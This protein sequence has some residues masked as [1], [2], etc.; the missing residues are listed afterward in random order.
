MV[1]WTWVYKH[2]FDTLHSVLLDAYPEVGLLNDMV[3]LF[4]VL[5][6]ICFPWLLYQF[7]FPPTVEASNFSRSLITLYLLFVCIIA[8]LIGLRWYVIVFSLH[9][10]DDYLF[11]ALF[12]YLFTVCMFSVGNVYSLLLHIL[13]F[14]YLLF[15]LISLFIL[16]C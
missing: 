9:F 1:Q 14:D 16:V 13:K 11:L 15:L 2:H 10:P 7:A 6:G 4:L 5:R 8:I 3:V 12:I